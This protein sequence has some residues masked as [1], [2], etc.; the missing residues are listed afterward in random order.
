M[1]VFDIWLHFA[2]RNTTQK[3]ITIKIIYKI[4]Q[5]I[6]QKIK[7]SILKHLVQDVEIGPR[8]IL[9]FKKRELILD[10]RRNFAFE[11]NW[12]GDNRFRERFMG[13]I[14]ERRNNSSSEKSIS[15]WLLVFQTEPYPAN[16]PS[17]LPVNV[18]RAF[19]NTVLINRRTARKGHSDNRR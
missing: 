5:K 9:Y 13:K 8:E 10:K 18:S 17:F 15:R 11:M 4:I 7:R 14:N 3:I 12:A 2:L 1:I 19:N 6:I 16:N